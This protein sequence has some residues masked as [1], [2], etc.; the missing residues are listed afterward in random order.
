MRAPL[1]LFRFC[2]SF[3]FFNF[4]LFL[5]ICQDFLL[6][7]LHRLPELHHKQI[8][9]VFD[10]SKFLLMPVHSFLHLNF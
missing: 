1:F 7:G 5:K 8:G 2:H 3:V 10:F 4:S 6:L 9:V